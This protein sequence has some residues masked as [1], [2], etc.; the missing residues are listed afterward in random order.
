MACL[1]R[2]PVRGED[3]KWSVGGFLRWWSIAKTLYQRRC[4]CAAVQ[5][6]SRDEIRLENLRQHVLHACMC[7][8]L[9]NQRLQQRGKDLA[10]LLILAPQGCHGDTVGVKTRSI[11]R[12][13]AGVL[14]GDGITSRRARNETRMTGSLLALLS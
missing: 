10:T 2:R 9:T 3:E 4:G 12:L 11:G 8:A 1:P 5:P 6:C 13:V 7:A 14:E